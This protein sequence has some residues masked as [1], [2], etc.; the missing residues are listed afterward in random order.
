MVS[1][2]YEMSIEV[3]NHFKLMP[4][5]KEYEEE[6][7]QLILEGFLEYFG[8][9][10]QNLNPDLNN[11]HEI[12]SKKGNV[13]LIGLYGSELIGTGGLVKED[14]HTARIVRMSVKEGYRGQGFARTILKELESI[15]NMNGYKKIVLETNNTWIKPINLY[16]TSGFV[17]YLNDGQRTHMVKLI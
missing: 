8:Y 3:Q 9:I 5:I 7:K 4:I 2:V 17:E 11:L 10:D 14:E 16:K 15:A 1:E 12:Y 6:S 13:F